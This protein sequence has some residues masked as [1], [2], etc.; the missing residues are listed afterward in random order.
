MHW[1]PLPLVL[2]AT[3]AAAQDTTITVTGKTLQE[4]R[5]Q[6]EAFVRK[7]TPVLPGGQFARRDSYCPRVFGVGPAAQK[8]VLAAV[9]EAAAAAGVEEAPENCKGDLAIVFSADSD[10]LIAAMQRRSKKVFWYI[11]GE[12]LR[13]ITAKG[14]AFRWWY[15]ANPGGADGASTAQSTLVGDAMG[16]SEVMMMPTWSSSLIETSLKMTLG[17]S[18]VLIDVPRNEGLPLSSVASYAAMLSFA[19]ISPRGDFRGLPSILA[20]QPGEGRGAQPGLTVWDRAYLRELYRLPNN[21]AGWTQRASLAA[22][23]AAGVD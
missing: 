23:V 17:G 11:P 5:A 22:K 3:I 21:R 12:D 19:Q 4:R 16:N 7:T 6:A 9:R 18:V 1:L 20:L 10:A 8:V 2:V 15:A 14:R 13:A